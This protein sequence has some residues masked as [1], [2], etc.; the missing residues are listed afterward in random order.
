MCGSLPSVRLATSSRIVGGEFKSFTWAKQLSIL[1]TSMLFKPKGSHAH[2]VEARIGLLKNTLERLLRQFPESQMS[3]ILAHS[4]A[5]LNALPGTGG[6][7][8]AQG[9]FG[10][11]KSDIFEPTATDHAFLQDPSAQGAFMAAMRVRVEAHCAVRRALLAGRAR[12]ILQHNAGFKQL[13]VRQG[14][15]VSFFGSSLSVNIRVCGPD[16]PRSSRLWTGV[17]T[18]FSRVACTMFRSTSCVWL[19][20]LLSR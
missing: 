18:F 11:V 9:V 2:M 1:G 15:F 19:R 16:P 14:D 17:H 3:D 13:A 6:F 8:P 20:S 5:V 7:S 12:R 10:F 4:S